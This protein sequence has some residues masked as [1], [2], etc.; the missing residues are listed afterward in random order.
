MTAEQLSE[1]GAIIKSYRVRDTIVELLYAFAVVAMGLVTLWIGLSAF[2]GS[3]IAYVLALVCLTGFFF[4]RFARFS[5]PLTLSDESLGDVA[6]ILAGDE[7]SLEKLRATLRNNNGVLHLEVLEK[8]VMEEQR[9]LDATV[10]QTLS[11]VRES[12][13]LSMPGAKALLGD[14]PEK[15]HE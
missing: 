7:D 11:E 10:Q 14:Q 3:R 1:L 9:K 12:R 15:A 5:T 6:R 4:S 2:N 8:I 13:L